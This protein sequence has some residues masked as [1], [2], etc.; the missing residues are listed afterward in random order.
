MVSRTTTISVAS[1]V[2]FWRRGY[3]EDCTTGGMGPCTGILVFHKASKITYGA[4]LSSPDIYEAPELIEMLAAASDEFK[5]RPDVT[6][7]VSEC[8][9]IS[10]LEEYYPHEIRA[11]IEKQIRHTL[12]VA[13]LN[14]LWPNAGT[15]DITLTLDPETGEM[16]VS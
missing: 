8:C 14:L 2:F 11:F 5:N 10:E 15:T 13:E 4:H 6:I 9:E 16:Y 7:Y 3:P 1:I 12:P